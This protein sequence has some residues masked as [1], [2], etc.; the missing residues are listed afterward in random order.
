V[1]CVTGVRKPSNDILCL[2]LEEEQL[3][4]FV[5]LGRAELG[6]TLRTLLL[7]KRALHFGPVL[8]SM[9]FAATLASSA[10]AYSATVEDAAAAG[11]VVALR[12]MLEANPSLAL[13]KEG[14]GTTPLHL[15]ALY[16][17]KEAASVLLAFH[18][19]VAARDENGDTPLHLAAAKGRPDLVLLLLNGHADVNARNAH[20]A[21]PLHAAVFYKREETVKLLIVRDAQVTAAD[22]DGETPLHMASQTGSVELAEMLL[23]NHAE[24]NARDAANVTP[25]HAAVFFK[26]DD[27]ARLLRERGGLQ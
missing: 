8:G 2:L 4:Q 16:G 27:V 17:H 20:G 19:D 13:A 24:I 6:G 15:A 25:L 11:D 12:A 7:L 9:V 10:L 5:P 18:A 3:T 23:A 1:F 14:D 22:N 21:M 26:H